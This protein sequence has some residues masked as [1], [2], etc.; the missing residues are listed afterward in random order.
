ML[1]PENIYGWILLL[2]GRE[3]TT[4]AR[5]LIKEDMLFTCYV[6]AM[7]SQIIPVDPSPIACRASLFLEHVDLDYGAQ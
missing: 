5:V 3:K 7:K 4:E 2:S 6:H 1:A